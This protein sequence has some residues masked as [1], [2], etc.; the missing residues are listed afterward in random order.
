[1]PGFES[2]FL[3]QQ[4]NL[5]KRPFDVSVDGNTEKKGKPARFHLRRAFRGWLTYPITVDSGYIHIKY[6]P[7]NC[8][9]KLSVSLGGVPLNSRVNYRICLAIALQWHRNHS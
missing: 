9:S 7:E 1:M 5:T 3:S 2:L 6:F 4:M 8:D